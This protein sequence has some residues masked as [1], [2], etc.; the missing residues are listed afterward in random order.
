MKQWA[1]VAALLFMLLAVGF[2]IFL[3]ESRPLLSS[4]NITQ[5]FF[6]FFV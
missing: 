6:N 2:R 5:K 4:G 1:A 3:S